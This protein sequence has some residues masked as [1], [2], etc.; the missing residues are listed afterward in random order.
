MTKVIITEPVIKKEP[1]E[2][3]RKR[4][5]DLAKLQGIPVTNAILTAS[6]HELKELEVLAEKV[7]EVG[8][9]SDAI[10]SSLKSLKLP[11]VEGIN[12]GDVTDASKIAKDSVSLFDEYVINATKKSYDN[13]KKIRENKESTNFDFFKGCI[14]FA[15]DVFFAIKSFCKAVRKKYPAVVV[16]EIIF[17]GNLA[18]VY[19]ALALTS[20][21]L[22]ACGY[23]DK[24]KE[25]I[26]GGKELREEAKKATG[27]KKDLEKE[28][29]DVRIEELASSHEKLQ[30]SGIFGSV[31]K[32]VSGPKAI[33][34]VATNLEASTEADKKQA[35]NF[36]N[37]LVEVAAEIPKSKEEV[38]AFVE[39]IVPG[40]KKLPESQQAI[41]ATLKTKLEEIKYGGSAPKRLASTALVL[42]KF[43]ESLVRSGGEVP[44]PLKELVSKMSDA[45]APKGIGKIA[46]IVGC[47]KGFTEAVTGLIKSVNPLA[48]KLAR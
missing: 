27:A 18:P 15:A 17:A 26:V 32:L 14:R 20:A 42:Q 23:T 39:R 31:V 11:A 8:D 22:T 25:L 33:V 3:M 48:Q 46:Q 5:K 12:L 4:V 38:S 2:D 24:T 30:A 47:G 29:G 19:S 36:V 37:K 6:E 41:I 43:T 9:N 40:S 35:V 7:R 44:K 28:Q 34:D 13:L 10:L 21:T 16:A 1:L 45:I